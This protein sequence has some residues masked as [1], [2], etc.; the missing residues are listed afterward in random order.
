MTNPYGALTRHNTGW[1]PSI[2]Y[3]KVFGMLAIDQFVSYSTID[4]SRIDTVG[5][6]YN[7]YGDFTPHNGIGESPRPSLSAI[8][9]NNFI[10][11]T[12][13]AYTINESHKLD[14]NE[15]GRAHV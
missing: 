7:W 14:A 10:S 13:V 3:R 1:V 12:H 11:R 6:T 15:I 9:F 2:R 5:G 4:R 8:N